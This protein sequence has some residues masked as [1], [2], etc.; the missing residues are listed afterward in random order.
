MELRAVIFDLDGVITDT[1]RFH[2]LCWK[3]LADQ[4]HVPFNTTFNE[5]FKGVS[6]KDC[7]RMLFPEIRD[8]A[9]LDELAEQKNRYYVE[10]IRQITPAD[11]FDGTRELLREL[12]D[13]GIKTAIGSA[14]KNT[15]LVLQKLGI[16][17][18]FDAV[19]NGT[20]VAHSKPAPDVFELCARKLNVACSECVVLEDA[21]AGV[22]AALAA[23]MTVVGIGS[24]EL[25]PNADWVVNLIQD[26]NLDIL[27]RLVLENK[28]FSNEDMVYL[29]SLNG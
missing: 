4:Y 29:V 16:A 12:R 17:A 18:G 15:P 13:H 22:Q 11:L 23:G 25:L 14:S 7:V 10:M 8:D 3:K 2:Y 1:S 9:R 26:L 24:R 6:R 20:E 28:R 19:A 21:Q 27:S 5:R